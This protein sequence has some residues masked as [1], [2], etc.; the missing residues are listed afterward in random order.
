[1]YDV[2]LFKMRVVICILL[3]NN[4]QGGTPFTVNSLKDQNLAS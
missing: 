4:L 3:A 1:V 2:K